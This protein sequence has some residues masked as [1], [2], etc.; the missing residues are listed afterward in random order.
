MKKIFE[1]DYNPTFERECK[2]SVYEMDENEY[3]NYISFSHDDWCM[4]FNVTDE[5]GYDMAG[6][7]YTSYDFS[8][9]YGFLTV[10]EIV[11]Y[12]V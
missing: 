4:Y 9:G 2:I 3:R 10:T 6:K 1:S 5:K 11:A 7:L 12:D 8:C